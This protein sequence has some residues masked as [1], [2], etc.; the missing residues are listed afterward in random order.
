MRSEAEPTAL[1]FAPGGI[2]I[3]EY[4]EISYH[5]LLSVDRV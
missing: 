2:S 1:V 5:A 3:P 4:Q